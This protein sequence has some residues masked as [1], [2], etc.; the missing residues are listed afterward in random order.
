MFGIARAR[1]S[2]AYRRHLG[3]EEQV[4]LGQCL[5]ERARDDP[6]QDGAVIVAAHVTQEAIDRGGG[7][8]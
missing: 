6:F 8:A 5:V 1:S 2:T 4:G 3:L 7:V